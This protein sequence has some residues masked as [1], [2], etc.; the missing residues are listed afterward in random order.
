MTGVFWF[1]VS[2]TSAKGSLGPLYWVP[3][4]AE[5]HGS[6]SVWWER[7]MVS[8]LLKRVRVRKKGERRQTGLS[9]H[10]LYIFT[11]KAT[12]MTHFLQIGPAF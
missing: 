6:G 7:L 5:P 4:E 12:S 8:C 9:P 3:G 10:M 11:W 1:T 2:E